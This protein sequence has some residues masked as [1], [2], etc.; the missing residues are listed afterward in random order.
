MT[1]ITFYVCK[2]STLKSRLLLACR[3]TEKARKHGMSVY[4]HMDSA[5]TTERMDDFLWGWSDTS[6]IPHAIAPD[7]TVKVL[8]GDDDFSEEPMEKCDY[9][10][11]LSNTIPSFFT[12]FKRMAEILDPSEENLRDGRQRYRFYQDNGYQ[13]DYH[14]L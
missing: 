9:L 7:S 6:F 10:I 13:L 8:L 4:I 1:Q 3:L 12:H 14:Q 2:V 11:N 5:R